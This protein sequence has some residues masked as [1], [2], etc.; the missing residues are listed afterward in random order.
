MVKLTQSPGGEEACR[1]L[2][3]NTSVGILKTLKSLWQSFL[4]K[5]K[6]PTDNT[7]KKV[8]YEVLFK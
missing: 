5:R 3:S 8:H 4:L 2:G 6:K 7:L 1:R